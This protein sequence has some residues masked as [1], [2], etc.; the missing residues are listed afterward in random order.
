MAKVSIIV[1]V[2]NTAEYLPKCIASLTAQS[3]DD[4]EIILVENCS[5][6]NS[7]EVCKKF[8]EG[9]NR[10]KVITIEVEIGRAHV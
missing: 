3:V 1:P 7:L 8:A 5:T 2:H 10:I 4:M 6:D 9:D